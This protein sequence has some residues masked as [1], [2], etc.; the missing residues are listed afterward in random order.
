ME[1]HRYKYEGP[2]MV[3]NTCIAN[4]WESETM[5]TSAIKA[6]SNLTYQYKKKHNL[7][8]TAKIDLPGKVTLV[9]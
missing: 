8:A 4:R 6:K 9:S 1:K 5:A 2:V 7:R 3:F